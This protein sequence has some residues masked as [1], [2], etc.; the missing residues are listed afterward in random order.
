MIEIR[1]CR[2]EDI[3]LVMSFIDCHWQS[4]HSLAVSLKLMD[5]QHG[6]ADGSYNYLIAIR[7]NSVLGILGYIPS[8][9][10]DAAL[11][12]MNV[13]WLALWK[14]LDNTGETGLGLRMLNALKNIEQ[15]STIAVNGINA[16]HPPMYKALRYET[17]ELKQF[18]VVNPKC[19]R[20]L[21]SAPEEYTLPIPQRGQS[22]F[23]EMQKKDLLAFGVDFISAEVAN[24]K[25][26]VYFSNRFLV[27]P[28]YK[29]RVFQVIGSTHAPALLAT[30]IAEHEGVRVLRI[31]DFSGD[32]KAIAAF[33]SAV[34]D[35]MVE[36][37]VEYADF[38]QQ[39]LP[40]EYF[41]AAGFALHDSESEVVLPN[42]FEPFLR[43]NGRMLFALKS[44]TGLP[45]VICRADGD[46][47]RPNRLPGETK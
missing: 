47:D 6:E 10:F 7:E 28:F 43:R 22:K 31:V 35:L 29:Y 40:D 19:K 30:R 16:A 39:G 14:V 13:I 11:S 32:P 25:S 24:P 17:G 46:Q 26:P 12:E 41:A 34:Y 36:E 45:A 15:H 20:N 44:T 27:H 2:N 33:G 23:V 37:G 38:W 4:G 8:R 18:F 5:W 9:R 21:L 1:R 42:Y 3:G